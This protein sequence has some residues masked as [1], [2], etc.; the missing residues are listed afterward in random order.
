MTDSKNKI[1]NSVNI[2]DSHLCEFFDKNEFLVFHEK[3]SKIVHSDIYI[4]K[5]SEDRP[6]NILMTCGLSAL[7]MN[8][9]KDFDHFT[10]A[11]II[12]LLPSNWKLNYNDF[13]NENNYWPLRTLIQL[14]KYPHRYDTWLGYGHTVPL[15]KIHKVN[16]NF[17]SIIL[18]E[19]YNLS[20]DF[21]LIKNNEKEIYLYSAIPIYKEELEY[22][23]QYGT[24]KL[25]EKFK[26]FDIDEIVDINRKNVCISS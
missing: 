21:T 25:L 7:P 9:P 17:E 23:I 6:Y 14:S 26:E 2:I 12:L 1:L 3:E 18:L 11:E 15:D 20:E 8:V 16:H 4:I 22:K 5:A 19:S 13:Q 24:D 10:F